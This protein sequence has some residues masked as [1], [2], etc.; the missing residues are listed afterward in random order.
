MP[1]PLATASPAASPSYDG[2][3]GLQVT[4]PPRAPQ[5]IGIEPPRVHRIPI[6]LIGIAS[7]SFL[8]PADDKSFQVMDDS[9]RAKLQRRR[10][11]LTQATPDQHVDD[12]AMYY[13]VVGECPK[14]RFYGL[15]LLRRK[16]RRYTDPGA[17]T[18]QLRR[19]RHVQSSIVLPSNYDK[20]WHL[21]RDNL[22]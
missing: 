1:A 7:F 14:G 15:G 13:N 21:C 16:K 2:R 4:G 11:E 9:I 22:G 18:S 8:C 20:L 10:Q 5:R 12:E 17:S 19:W 3:A 6:T